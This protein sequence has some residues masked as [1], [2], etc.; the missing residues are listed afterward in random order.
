MADYS[1]RTKVIRRYMH[2][3]MSTK[4][5]P[6]WQPQQ[7]Q[8]VYRFLQKLLHSPEN[9]LA[10]IRHTAG[11]TVVRLTYGYTPKDEGDEYIKQA[12]L[13]MGAFSLA[14][15]PGA[16]LVDT[17]PILKY[18]P[19]APFKRIATEWRN[20]LTE[21]IDLPMEFVRE[22]TQRGV[23]E[24]SF[25][26]E[27]LEE[28]GHKSD[29]GLIPAAAASLYAGGADTTVS[30]VTSFF[31]AMLHYPGTQKLAQKEIEE[32]LGKDR[33]PTFADRA[34]L[35]Y[36]EAVFKEVMRWQPLAPIGIPHRLDSKSDDEHNE[37]R[38]PANSMVIANI[39]H[40]LRDPS[41][42]RSPEVFD[43]SRFWGLNTEPDPE[44][45][46]FGFGRRRC[47]GMAVAHSSVWLS[48]ALTLAA[49]DITAPVGEHG[50]PE[51]PSLEYSNSTVRHPK[52]FRCNLLPRSEKMKKMIEDM[53]L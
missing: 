8:Q 37:M 49:Y 40:M 5:I 46:V 22:Q 42:Y 23:A 21:L 14:S 3:S 20:Q 6:N 45:V 47:P 11:A 24:P 48:I 34:S 29:K 13:V 39:W 33:L 38:I 50:N 18:V 44:E 25:V 35:P 15:T 36:V 17:F 7:E 53:A 10:H 16:F 4:A 27:W 43:P 51:L 9:L 52:P 30:V 32:V 31:V 2:S 12:E 28:P 1:E 19:W 41:V 26:A